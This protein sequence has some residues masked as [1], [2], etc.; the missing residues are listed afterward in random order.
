M[1]YCAFQPFSIKCY[2]KS[3]RPLKARTNEIRGW[4]VGEEIHVIGKNSL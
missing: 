1:Y 2:R 3:Q 4:D